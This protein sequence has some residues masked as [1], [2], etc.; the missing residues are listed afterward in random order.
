MKRIIVFLGLCC[1]LLQ[2][3]CLKFGKEEWE[4]LGTDEKELYFVNKFGLNM[5][6]VYYL[7]SEEIQSGL[8]T[9]K[10]SSD[11]IAKVREIR[12]KDEAGRDIDKWSQMT[13]DYEA[14]QGY[15]TGDTRSNGLEFT[16]FYADET[17]KN[18]VLAVV[19]T[20]PDSPAS[21]LGLKRGDVIVALNNTLLTP[22]N[23]SEVIYNTLYS[24]NPC[25]ITMADGTDK[26]LAVKDMYVN[27]IIC[28]KV[29]EKDGRKIGY[30][31]Y[32]SYTL[33]SCEEL[34]DIFKGF[35]EAGITELVLD[36]RYNGG[37]YSVTSEVLAS[38]IVPLKEVQNESV[39]QKDVYNATLNEAWG[40]EITK[41]G[42]AHEYSDE[43]GKHSVST[44]GA[45]PDISKLTVIM[46]E[47]TASASEATVCGLLPYMDI[48]LVGER[49][50]GKY[51]GGFIVD[52]PTFYG[53]VKDELSKS[54]YNAAVKYSKNWG[55]YVMVSRYADKDG[56]TPCMPNGFSPDVVVSDNPLDGYQL[57][58]ER[59]TML[60]AALS[61]SGLSQLSRPVRKAPQAV[62]GPVR[63][64]EVRIL[65]TRN[66]F[67]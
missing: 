65:N 15:V 12:Y 57:G 50:G 45:N 31:H 51:C 49:S 18:V 17:K 25:T 47:N 13:D 63:H 6:S 19:Y 60:A 14:F 35:K 67:E 33:K 62:P 10:Y 24:G 41:F 26:H 54:E 39:F 42:T 28:H 36:L 7:W 37:G 5:M 29:I 61:G 30:L 66:I 52:G 32:T 43:D 8:S 1:L 56:N 34:V 16:P 2:T 59:E 64:P 22:S 53:W 38:M 11:P 23:Y 4:R 20:Y 40:E 48:K 58:D 21:D 46:T 55:I 27:P 44:S 9:W 3:S